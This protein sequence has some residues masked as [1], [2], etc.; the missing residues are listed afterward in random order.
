VTA[1]YKDIFDIIT[2]KTVLRISETG[3]SQYYT[4]YLNS[5]YGRVRGVEAEYKK[6]IGN[7]F[8]GALSGSYSIATGKSSTPNENV[9]RLQQGEPETIKENY[10]IWDRPVQI[11][12]NLNITIPKGEPLFGLWEG[13]LDD[14]NFFVRLFY[15]S[16]KRYTPVLTDPLGRPLITGFDA[17]TGR[18]QYLS[19]F[20][21]LNEEVGEYWFYVDLNIEKAFDLGF[22]K[23]I[24]T[25]EVQNLFDRKNSQI[26][27]PLT[28]RAYEYGDPTPTSYNDPVYPQLSGDISPFPYNPARYLNPRTVRLGL[29]YRF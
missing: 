7:W 12:A 29:A 16:G 5:D 18:P 21:R 19:D 28:G 3:G 26:I 13:L 27:N 15:E 23:L 4:T 8:R 24:A 20:N 1:F 11:S 9:I 25:I 2:E 14:Y 17:V 6:R 22:G 10:L